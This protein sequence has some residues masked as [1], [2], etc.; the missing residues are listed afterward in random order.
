MD[1]VVERCCGLDV[2]K[3]LIVACVHYPGPD[4]ERTEEIAEFAA[5]T[6]DLLALR[7]FLVTHHV[8]RVGMEATGVYWKAPFYVLEDVTDVWLL[9]ARHMRNVPGRKTDV[10]DAQWICQLVEH[11]L[12]RPSFVPPPEIRDLRELTRYRRTLTEERGREA[13]R[14]DKVLQDAGIK[15]SSVATDILGKSGRDMLDA[16]CAGTSDPVVLAEL[17]RGK[18][19]AKI[20]MFHKAFVGRF[21]RRHVVIVSEILAHLDY[22][23]ESIGRLTAEIDELIAPFAD[24]RER[25]CT[26]PGIDARIAEA[27]IGEIGVDMSRFPTAGHLASWAGMCPGQH[28]SAGRSRSGRARHGDSW[29]QRHLAVAAMAAARSK[30]TY[31]ASQYRR[32]A[33][34]RGKLRARKA[35]GHSIL[36]ICWHILSSEAATYADL[37]QDWFDRRNSPEL[38]ARRKLAELRSLGCEVRTNADG[39]TTVALPAA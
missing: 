28:E 12:V 23:E 1:V 20:P 27:I 6:E 26:I 19:R 8:T 22:L 36:V 18:L 30:G 15:L 29:L 34:R 2:H 33:P 17:A 39:T 11:G 21:G 10:K 38:R 35:V 5:F 25:L 9:N 31:L 32:L 13:Q 24:A 37:G 16:L 3:D 14:L 4:G 7:D